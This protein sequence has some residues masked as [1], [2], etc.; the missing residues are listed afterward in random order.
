MHSICEYISALEVEYW[1]VM[2]LQNTTLLI[3][4]LCQEGFYYTIT[5]QASYSS[6]FLCWDSHC[7][8]AI[9]DKI[10]IIKFF[11]QIVITWVWLSKGSTHNI[12]SKITHIHGIHLT[13]VMLLQKEKKWGRDILVIENVRKINTKKHQIWEFSL[14]WNIS[15]KGRICCD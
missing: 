10:F 9:Q 8:I 2:L 3:S 5:Y 6:V 11:G 1:M 4:E 7:D 13:F 14:N 15:E 12:V